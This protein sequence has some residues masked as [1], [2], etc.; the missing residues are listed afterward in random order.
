MQIEAL[1]EG[2]PVS[3]LRSRFPLHDNATSTGAVTGEEPK[4]VEVLKAWD[5]RETYDERYAR[6][7]LRSR[8]VP[9][10]SAPIK[11]PSVEEEE[12]PEGSDTPAGIRTYGPRGIGLGGTVV[13]HFIK[14]N[15]WFLEAAMALL[16]P[17][18]NGD[19][20]RINAGEAKSAEGAKTVIAKT[21][22]FRKRQEASE[23]SAI[24]L[25]DDGLVDSDSDQT[26]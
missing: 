19:E 25:E 12:E 6:S 15:E 20:N 13:V 1:V 22:S 17:S 11:P 16:G 26:P 23:D 21:Q 14:R 8:N 18:W 4:W 5:G 9:D 24:P 3:R 2:S 10:P 7:T